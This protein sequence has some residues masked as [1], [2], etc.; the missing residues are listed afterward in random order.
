MK[1]SPRDEFKLKQV[2]S[3]NNWNLGDLHALLLDGGGGA[4]PETALKLK[5]RDQRYS[6]PSSKHILR[7]NFAHLKMCKTQPRDVLRI[8]LE[9]ESYD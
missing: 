4:Y 7:M 5:T 3:L 8:C 1:L 6:Q 9:R 2:A